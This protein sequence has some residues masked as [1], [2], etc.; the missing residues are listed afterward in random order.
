MGYYLR[1]AVALVWGSILCTIE[2][3][4]SV[5]SRFVMPVRIK[6]SAFFFV[7]NEASFIFGRNISIGRRTM[8]D[9]E[10][11]GVLTLGDNVSINDDCK[12]VC[13]ENI[14]IGKDTILGSNVHIYDHDHLFDKDAGVNRKEYKRSA[15]SI[16]ERCWIG[17]GTIIL[18][19]TVIGDNCLIA[20]GS[21]IKGNYP[22]GSKVVQK[23]S[24]VLH[25]GD[26]I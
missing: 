25:G 5:R 18:R 11:G 20:A 9:V 26:R 10:N 1:T 22:N 15:V 2:R 7:G 4:K 12:I 17:A 23:R 8:C 19:G 16:G 13:H 6:P 3:L 21:V 24:T 14:T